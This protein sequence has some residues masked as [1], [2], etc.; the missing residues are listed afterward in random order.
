VAIVGGGAIGQLA[1][2]TVLLSGAREVFLVEISEERRR[3]AAA[4]AGVT[5]IDPAQGVPA[6]QIKDLNGGVPPD[7]VIECS[8]A[9][10]G[11]S[12]AVQIAGIGGTVVVGG[13]CVGPATAF[14]FGDEFLHNRVTLKASM[15]VWGC[16]SRH[17]PEWSRPRLLREVLGVLERKQ[18]D[19]EGFLSEKVAF[20]EAQRAYDAIR[21]NPGG[22]LKVALTY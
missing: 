8:G 13:F 14:S 9:V 16:P 7:R 18:L 1:V 2:Q 15:S 12:S 3:F 4:R 20:T 21:E 10:A 5:P 17:G 19:L 22:I 11:L 6:V